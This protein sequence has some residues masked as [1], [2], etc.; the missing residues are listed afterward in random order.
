MLIAGGCHPRYTRNLGTG[1][2]TVTGSRFKPSTHELHFGASRVVLP[3][4]RG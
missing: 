3:V 1:E 2:A 4:E